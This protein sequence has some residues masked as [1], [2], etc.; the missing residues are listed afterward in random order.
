MN[1][2]GNFCLNQ[3]HVFILMIF[4]MFSFS[5]I[6]QAAGN[7][8]YEIRI[9]KLNSKAQEDRIDKYLKDAYIPALHRA[10]ISKVGVFKPIESDTVA[11]EIIVVWIPFK[12]LQQFEELPKM[13]DK[14][15][16][17][18][19][20]GKDYIDAVYNNTPYTRIEKI[21]L[22]S[23]NEMPQFVVPQ[24]KTSA[25]ERI[26]ELRSYQGP[27]EKMFQTK[28]EMFNQGGEVKIFKS[29]NFN[30]VFFAEVIAGSTM[31]NLMYLTTF[32]DM[33]SHDEHWNSFRNHPDWKVLSG[34]EKYKNTVSKAVVWL[35]HP[36]NYSEI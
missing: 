7:D 1:Q 3:I 25:S 34:M 35:L 36:T 11:G 23:F 12:S 9:Y 2:L 8:Y 5:K 6:T 4:L 27:T 32:S 15:V 14:D 17:Y 24:H 19:S 22:K 29:L 20:D 21:L 10:G 30:P 28:V 31:P 13:L 26:Y 16:K 33:K 18:Q